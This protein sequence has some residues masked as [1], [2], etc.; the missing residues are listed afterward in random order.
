[1]NSRLERFEQIA[2]ALAEKGYSVAD[3]FLSPEEVTSILQVEEFKNGLSHFKKAGIG[4][5]Q[6]KKVNEGIRGDY[7]QWIDNATA[8]P[9]FKIYLDRLRELIGY[10]NQSLF[11]SVKDFEVHLTIY[12]EGSF[13]QRHLDQ[14]K[15]CDHRKLS[16]IFYLNEGWKK[17][18][19]GQLRIHLAEGPVDFFPVAGRLV[20]FRSDKI[21]HEVLP[22]TRE[23]LSLTGWILDQLAEL[24]QL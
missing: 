16:V 17:E 10:I 20:C 23:R 18:H 9:E 19:G 22:A 7:I 15:R 24:K 13:Y 14:F 4:K 6:E 1:M 21:E 11:L 5:Q 3:Q 2:S 8:R 12:P